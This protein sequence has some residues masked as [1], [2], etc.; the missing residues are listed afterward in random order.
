MA[1]V[2]AITAARAGSPRR[3]TCCTTARAHEM[4]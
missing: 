3:S 1:V 2:T 4:L